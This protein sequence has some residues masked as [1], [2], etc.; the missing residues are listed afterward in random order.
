M[1][2]PSEQGGTHFGR[3]LCGAVRYEVRG[4][5]R[6]VVAC[7]CSNCRRWHG[8][9]GAYTSASI[10]HVRIVERRSLRWYDSTTDAT[11]NVRRG[12]CGTCGSSLFWHPHD[13]DTISIAA[14]TLD[15]PTGL[16]TVGHIWTSCGGDYYE[17]CDGLPRFVRG[18][19][20]TTESATE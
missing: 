4:P 9:H 15:A 14:G 10:H 1:G 3:C 11:P 18:W 20:A 5:L 2:P 16:A 7:H 13:Q 19:A 8:H 12:F 17:L 6:G